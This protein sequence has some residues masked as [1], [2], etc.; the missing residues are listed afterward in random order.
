MFRLSALDTYNEP[1]DTHFL[2]C[3]DTLIFITFQL[4]R[5]K[6]GNCISNDRPRNYYGF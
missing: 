2:D 3:W 4:I 1:R 5:R 6:H